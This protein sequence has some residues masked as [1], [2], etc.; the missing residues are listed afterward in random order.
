MGTTKLPGSDVVKIYVRKVGNDD[1][2]A[3]RRRI[4]LRLPYGNTLDPLELLDLG[5]AIDGNEAVFEIGPRWEDVT[6]TTYYDG[7]LDDVPGE[8]L[9]EG[10]LIQ[11]KALVKFLREK[12]YK[13][14]FA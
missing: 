11:Q 3:D 2:D 6:R 10:L 1:N 12:G 4:S 13:P 5:L 9:A 8:S 7:P 14:E